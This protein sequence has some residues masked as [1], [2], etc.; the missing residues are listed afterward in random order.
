MF[1]N[2]EDYEDFANFNQ[3]NLHSFNEQI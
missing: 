2:K 1:H 3:G